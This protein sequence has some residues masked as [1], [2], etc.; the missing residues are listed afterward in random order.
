MS[1]K[2]LELLYKSKEF[3]ENDISYINEQIENLEQKFTELEN[4]L[5]NG[6]I[7]LAELQEAID[8]LEGKNASKS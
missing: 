6:Q 4:R 2:A 1:K 3:L 7:D 5:S 8:I